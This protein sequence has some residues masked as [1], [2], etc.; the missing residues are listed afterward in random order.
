MTCKSEQ[1]FLGSRFKTRSHLRTF[2]HFPISHYSRKG[3]R[4]WNISSFLVIPGDPEITRSVGIIHDRG[5]FQASLDPPKSQKRV[6]VLNPERQNR[7]SLLHSRKSHF[8][9]SDA[10]GEAPLAFPEIQFLKGFEPRT[11]RLVLFL[12]NS[13]DSS[14]IWSC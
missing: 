10:T 8:R 2:S 3:P 7:R 4:S 11:L 1:G 13:S 6:Q 9:N 12:R 5:P 14:R